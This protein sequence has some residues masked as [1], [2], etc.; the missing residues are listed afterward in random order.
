MSSD[1]GETE[2]P[3]SGDLQRI[4]EVM[5]VI[6]QF[7]KKRLRLRQCLIKAGP[8]N[9]PDYELLQ[10]LFLT[11]AP[12]VD[13]DTVVEELLTHFGGLAEVMSAEIDAL[14]AAGLSAYEIAGVKF[15]RE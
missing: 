7:Y 11:I 2:L 3:G 4:D 12:R 8:E 13:P 5:K 6:L 15:V 14:A 10:I 1:E 9:L